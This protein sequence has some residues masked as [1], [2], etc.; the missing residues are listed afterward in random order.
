M[1][2]RRQR[3][4]ARTMARNSPPARDD[5]GAGEAAA[6]ACAPECVEIAENGGVPHEVRVDESV[7]RLVC[8]GNHEECTPD[9]KPVQEVSHDY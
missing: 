8:E 7:E 3:E 9:P 4:A 1:L 6:L 2:P 5:G